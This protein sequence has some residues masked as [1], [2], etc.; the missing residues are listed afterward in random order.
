MGLKREIMSGRY[1][2]G[3]LLVTHAIADEFGTSISPVRDAMQRLVGARLLE[4]H[5]GGGF[6]MPSITMDGLRDLYI[7]HGQLLRIA[8]KA[9]AR[10]RALS[11]AFDDM[12]VISGEDP[13]EI[14]TAAAAVFAAIGAW[15]TNREHL[16]AI[17][18]AGDRLHS[19]RLC[20]ARLITDAASELA[21]VQTLTI[22][23]SENAIRDA[24]WA[25]HRRRLRRI[26]GLVKEMGG[27][28]DEGPTD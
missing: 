11:G 7:W 23:G 20:E 3:Y 19:V 17:E 9:G 22:S 21:A 26:R 8:L 25:Y 13:Q 28:I 27:T 2:P 1:P 16:H 24:I 12:K 4:L 18:G 14:A 10:E 5:P 15:S 6:Q